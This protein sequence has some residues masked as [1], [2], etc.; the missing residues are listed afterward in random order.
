MKAFTLS[1]LSALFAGLT[2]AAPV[3]L[4]RR[5]GQS[6]PPS[7]GGGGS[8]FNEVDITILQFALT[9]SIHPVRVSILVIGV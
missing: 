2:L 8:G 6:G 4:A 3:D 5:T 9:V 1:A 7:Q